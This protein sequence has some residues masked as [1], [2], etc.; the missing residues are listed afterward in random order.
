MKRTTSTN[1]RRAFRSCCYPSP[2]QTEFTHYHKRNTYVP[3]QAKM[4]FHPGGRKQCCKDICPQIAQTNIH[5]PSKGPGSRS[6]RVKQLN[7][8]S[9]PALLT[10][11]PD[12]GVS[13]AGLLLPSHITPRTGHKMNPIGKL[14]VKI[15]IGKNSM[16]YTSSPKSS[17]HGKLA[18]TSIS[19]QPATHPQSNHQPFA[20]LRHPHPR[21]LCIRRPGPY[22]TQLLCQDTESNTLRIQG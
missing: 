21:P 19:C 13:V 14:P 16:S 18:K 15:T 2:T 6:Q 20:Q 22:R 10:T 12:S 17:S 3:P 1:T 11:L 7:L 4:R 9:T 5:N 8:E